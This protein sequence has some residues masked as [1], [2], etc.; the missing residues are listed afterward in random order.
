MGTPLSLVLSPDREVLASVS[1]ARPG[2]SAEW[3][4]NTSSLA[5]AEMEVERAT[6][7]RSSRDDKAYEELLEVV[8]RAVDRLKLD[9]PQEQETPKRLK[10][11]DRILSDG[12]GEGP[13]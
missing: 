3:A 13:Q 5:S 11:D 6:S 12:R 8:T 10:L 2:T 4:E 9:W 7:E 1:E